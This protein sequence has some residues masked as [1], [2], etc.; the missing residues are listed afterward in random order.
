MNDTTVSA[1]LIWEEKLDRRSKRISPGLK[2][3]PAS[4]S[5][6]AP[7]YFLIRIYSQK[8][9]VF[10]QHLS[11]RIATS[12]PLSSPSFPSLGP[13]PLSSPSTPVN[14]SVSLSAPFLPFLLYQWCDHPNVCSSSYQSPSVSYHPRF[15]AGAG[16]QL[17]RALVLFIFGS[18][19][20]TRFASL[21]KDA[22]SGLVLLFLRLSLR[23]FAI[24]FRPE[25]GGPLLFLYRGA[26]SFIKRKRL[27][28]LFFFS[29]REREG[30]G[31]KGQWALSFF[32]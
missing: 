20:P 9:R 1:P 22:P 5:N 11:L 2:R 23:R 7:S 14:Q 29:W 18:V 8:W 28:L 32:A 4:L 17:S 19:F 30:I 27:C 16:L 25:T 24:A 12:L 21:S 15:R 3:K 13:P 6:L 31:L 10:Q 26:E